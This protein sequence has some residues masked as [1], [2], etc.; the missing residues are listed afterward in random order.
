MKLRHYVIAPLSIYRHPQPSHDGVNGT[1]PTFIK[2]FYG[3]ITMENTR[4]ACRYHETGDVHIAAYDYGHK[5]MIV[6][7]GR[8]NKDGNYG[9][10]GGDTS[11]WKAYNRPYL[12]FDLE[13][14]YV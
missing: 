11:V 8:V 4:I 1:L 6:S 2:D 12:Q 10:E 3:N 5:Q 9:P 7:I 13:V 14:L